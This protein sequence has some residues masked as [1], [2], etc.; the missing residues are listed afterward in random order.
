MRIPQG[1]QVALIGKS[2]S[3]L[4]RVQYVV[5]GTSSGPAEEAIQI[6]TA[7]PKEADFRIEL[8]ELSNNLVI[9]VRLVDQYGLSS[10]QIPRYLLTMQETLCQKSTQNWMASV[11]Q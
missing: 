9:E 8:G 3:A 11:S 6:L 2:S 10:D 4:Q 7:E 1:T 5:R